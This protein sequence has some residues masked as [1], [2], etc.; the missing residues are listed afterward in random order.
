MP[1]SAS[2]W[3]EAARDPNIRA[4][5]ES[6]YA[7]VAAQTLARR[8][9]CVASGRCCNFEKFG[10]RLYVTGLE[11]A[12]L[13]ASLTLAANRVHSHEPATRAEDDRRPPPASPTSLTLPQIDRA[14][15]RG[16]CPFLVD[17]LCSVHAIK[18]L[19]CRV[20]FCDPTA[21]AWQMD[22]SEVGLARIRN[23][24]DRHRIEYRYGEWRVMLESVVTP[25]EPG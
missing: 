10:H 20:Y 8:P 7:H 21:Q 14:R 4:E 12:Y 2:S 13:V 15:T 16:D 3:L 1:S 17:R 24:H 11:A 6:V 25:G 19:G 22:L 23:I 9:L 18:P 5:L